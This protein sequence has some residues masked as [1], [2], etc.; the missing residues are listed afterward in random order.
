MFISLVS[1][2]SAIRRRA[3]SNRDVGDVRVPRAGVASALALRELHRSGVYRRV[4]HFDGRAGPGGR[5]KAFGTGRTGGRADEITGSSHGR[6]LGWPRTG[7]PPVGGNASGQP[8]GP[9]DRGSAILALFPYEGPF[10]PTRPAT[11]VILR[12]ADFGRLTRLAEGEVSRSPGSVRAVSALHRV[13][14]KSVGDIIVD[15]EIELVVFGR[16]PFAWRIPVASARDIEATL[17]G[18]W[19]PI[20]IEPGGVMGTLAIPRAGNHLL[21]IHR[22]AIARADAGFETLSLPVNAMPSARVVVEPPRDGEQQGELNALGGTRLQADRSVTGRLGPTDRIEVRWPQPE[23]APSARAAGPV[24]G[25][26]LWDINPAGDRVRWRF[27]FHQS[28]ELS[29][30]R[31]AHQP[32]LILRSGRAGASVETVWEENARQDEWTLRADPPLQ[33]G[34]TIELDCW[35]PADA[36]RADGGKSPA[37]GDVAAGSVRR[38]PRLQP[39]GVERYSG[40]V[41]VRRPGDWSGRFD[42]IPD[43][44]PISDESFVK[45]WGSLP[46]EPLTLCGTSRFV[47][48]CQASLST[49]P[50]PTRI[51]VKPTVHLEL[52]SGRI[53]MT[54]EAELSELSGHLQRIEAQLP[55]GIRIVEVTGDGL[56][57]WTMTPLGRLR[58]M[59]DR[60]LPRSGRLLRIHAWIPLAEDPLKIGSRQ[61]R[62]RVP[63][64]AWDGIDEIAGFLTVSSIAKPDLAGSTGLTA[65]SSESSGAGGT[66]PPRHR[67]TYRVDDPRKLG[68]IFWESIPARVN[69]SIESQMTIH[70][71]SAEWVA[72]L[73]YDVVGGA[74]DVIHIKMP[75]SWAAGAELRL[76][77]GGYQLTTETRGASAFWTITP[78][79][80]I[81]GSQRF[82]VRSTR[83][84]GAD[85]EIVHPEISPLG[86]GAVNVYLGI[87]NATGRPPTVESS[88]GLEKIPYATRFQAREFAR[89][90]GIPVSAFRV[91]GKSWRLVVR[92][93]RDAA[94]ATES[95][96]GSARLAFG[97]MMVVALPDRSSIGR[98]VYETV[99]E[100]GSL[101]SFELPAESSLLWATV[102]SSP[103]T[104]LR[105]SSGIWS[106]ALDD[107]RQSRVSLIWKTEPTL[108]SSWGSTWPVVLPRT[109][110]GPATTVVAVYTPPQVKIQGDFAGLEPTTMARVEMARADWLAARSI[111]DLVAKIDRSSGRDHEK[112]VSLLTS[113]MKWQP[114]RV[115]ERSNQMG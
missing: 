19:L 93:P 16:A 39:I 55:D 2:S 113:T 87:V 109:G 28:Q 17:D 25:L 11:D 67:L 101:L 78:E 99:P 13:A 68:E 10:D 91:M 82:V 8:A 20:S 112:L 29:T 46:N 58:L 4:H 59:F 7:R 5:R 40:S 66:T 108:S 79:R 52:E 32:G 106:I 24:E 30:I 14:R 69:V 56:T 57:D 31:F 61:H 41:G 36:T 34:A 64:I 107:R 72:V 102:D 111:A 44:E 6:Q 54:V 3:G 80:P 47:R 71:D 9:L 104:P 23:P 49:G 110:T 33:A 83:R 62:I 65:I 1:V 89:S 90:A 75:V 18:E 15:S 86:R 100:S 95:E 35:M 45:S 94:E 103:A 60:P 105:S 98:A 48:D 21:R 50:A 84:L 26:I 70:P 115:P 63:W 37:A 27:T 74:L 73:R 85:R 38:L 22:S 97:D 43:T 96:D 42:P 77:G 76:T 53:A 81:W 92:L 51:L 88:T 12:L 114:A